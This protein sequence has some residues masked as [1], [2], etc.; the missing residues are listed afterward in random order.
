M[1]PTPTTP[2]RK[3]VYLRQ[4]SNRRKAVPYPKSNDPIE[5]QQ[6]YSPILPLGPRR[7][8]NECK[9]FTFFFFIILFLANQR[10]PQ[11]E[12]IALMKGAN[13]LLLFSL[14]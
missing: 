6:L 2:E 13:P 4:T 9:N 11:L 14:P 10:M 5:E 7:F 12:L 8:P 3:R 1:P